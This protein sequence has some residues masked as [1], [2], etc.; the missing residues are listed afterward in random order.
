MSKG[1]H[2][3]RTP[4]VPIARGFNFRALCACVRM[5]DESPRSPPLLCASNGLLARYV[6]TERNP[7]ATNSP[8]NHCLHS[9][10]SRGD[11]LAEEGGKILRLG[12]PSDRLVQQRRQGA[13]AIPSPTSSRS[14]LV[15]SRSIRAEARKLPGENVAQDRAML[16]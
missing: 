9:D 7:R 5:S 15:A 1:K 8:S 3:V 2:R 16:L 6:P 11:A 10:S 13:R 12:F 14:D 4:Y